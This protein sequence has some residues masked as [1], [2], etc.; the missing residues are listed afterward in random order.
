MAQLSVA[1][2]LLEC[3]G[4]GAHV[5][6]RNDE[7]IRPIAD[8]VVRGADAVGKEER[9]SRRGRLVDDDPPGFVQREQR[10]D[11]RSRVLLG[12][13]FLRQVAEQRERYP[14]LP[15]ELRQLL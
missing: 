8:E 14:Q 1:G 7:A 9:Q 3:R 10:E 12:E 15:R 5:L 4:R 2:Q 13:C 6:G 11:I